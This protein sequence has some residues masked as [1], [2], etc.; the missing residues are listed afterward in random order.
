[1]AVKKIFDSESAGRPAYSVGMGSGSGSNL[2]MTDLYFAK[3][4]VFQYVAWLTDKP[5][6]RVFEYGK[7]LQLLYETR[8]PSFS[9]ISLPVR[10]TKSEL[11]Y[12]TRGQR[13]S[14]EAHDAY[15]KEWIKII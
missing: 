4:P 5:E 7:S 13:M 8:N 10:E 14:D 12:V 9:A 1:M 15:D 11:G 3:N 2:R 6:S